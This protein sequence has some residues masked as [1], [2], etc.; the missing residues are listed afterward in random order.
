V[1]ELL[2]FGDFDYFYLFVYQL[3]CSHREKT[4]FIAVAFEIDPDLF[5]RL[6]CFQS[7]QN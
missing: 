5:L 1:I 6:L 3:K 4:V 7:K 2:C